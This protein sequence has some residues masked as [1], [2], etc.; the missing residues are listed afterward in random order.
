MVQT[1][2]DTDNSNSPTCQPECDEIYNSQNFSRRGLLAFIL[3]RYNRFV[4]ELEKG[5]SRSEDPGKYFARGN[6]GIL[7]KEKY[8]FTRRKRFDVSDVR[9]R[10]SASPSLSEIL[11][12]WQTIYYLV[13]NRIV[14]F[15][16]IS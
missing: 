15:T 10:I 2:M 12:E 7:L 1:Q 11:G 5:G 9:N 13:S 14:N 8:L 3:V 4:S 16:I 6:V